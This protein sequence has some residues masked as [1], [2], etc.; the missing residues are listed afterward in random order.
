MTVLRERAARVVLASAV[1]VAIGWTV[2]V[3]APG[4]TAARNREDRQAVGSLPFRIDDA[5]L[6]DPLPGFQHLVRRGS[7]GGWR[8]AV[9]AAAVATAILGG[10][11]YGR[12]RARPARSR[13]RRHLPAR[14][15]CRAPPAP[16]RL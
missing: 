6:Q 16:Q 1:L 3:P 2:S 10:A 9:A 14:R 8:A 7:Q 11:R 4:G 12:R 5:A 13:R 15:W